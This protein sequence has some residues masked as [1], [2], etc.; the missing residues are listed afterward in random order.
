MIPSQLCCYTNGNNVCIC[1]IPRKEGSEVGS[2]SA[3][4]TAPP[5]WSSRLQSL[6][7]KE[8]N[9]LYETAFI[10]IIYLETRKKNCK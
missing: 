7:L 1:I 3:P 4:A 2:A 5:I 10:V 6:L 8:K 9:Q